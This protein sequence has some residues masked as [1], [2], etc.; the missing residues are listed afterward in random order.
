MFQEIKW[1]AEEVKTLKYSLDALFTII[2]VT[3]N[4]N[5]HEKSKGLKSKYH[6]DVDKTKRKANGILKKI[7]AAQNFVKQET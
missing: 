1:E 5:L 3:K 6:L 2:K 4:T 7:L